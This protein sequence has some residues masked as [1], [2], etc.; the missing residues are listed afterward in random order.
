MARTRTTLN[1]TLTERI[2]ELVQAGNYIET[3]AKAAGIHKSTYYSWMNRGEKAAEAQSKG[4]PVSDDEAAFADFYNQVSQAEAV[5]ETNAVAAVREADR[6]WQAH[7]TYLERRFATRWR[8][9]SGARY[10]KDERPN[11]SLEESLARIQREQSDRGA[12]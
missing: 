8:Q 4:D 9:Q 7:M 3:A 1:H 11:E 6:G 10:V 12:A 5:A 2:V